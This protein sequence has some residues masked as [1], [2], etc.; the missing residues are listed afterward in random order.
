[1]EIND[2]IGAKI[3]ELQL[4]ER[5][6]QAISMEKQSIQV[7]LN[8]VDNA[9]EELK[10]SGDEVYKVLNGIM[11]RS[12]KDSLIKEMSEKKKVLEMRISSIQKQETS[13]DSRA[14]K[15][16]SEINASFVEKK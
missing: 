11:I 5:N 8:G 7:E 15:L 3:Q 10:K 16:R 6:I 13:V 1:M 12:N 14:E 4:I 2:E 9:L